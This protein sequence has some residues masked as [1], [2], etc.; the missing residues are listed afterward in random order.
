MI[1][2]FNE[3]KKE[4]NWT[5]KIANE[6]QNSLFKAFKIMNF[7]VFWNAD[8]PNFMHKFFNAAEK[9][10]AKSKRYIFLISL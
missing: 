6:M 4:N 8:I 2:K 5:F 7:R 1:K 10:D 3:A 9:D